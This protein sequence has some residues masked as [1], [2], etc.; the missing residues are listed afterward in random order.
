MRSVNS[1]N[2]HRLFVFLFIALSTLLTSAC[3]KSEINISLDKTNL[4]S[5]QS[6]Q[7]EIQITPPDWV[8]LWADN[9][10]LGYS[11]T[12]TA[13]DELGAVEETSGFQF[14]RL[15]ADASSCD[16]LD[17][18]QEIVSPKR[19]TEYQIDVN[20]YY[21]YCLFC[22]E[23]LDTIQK[24]IGLLL[25]DNTW[26]ETTRRETLSISVNLDVNI[27]DLEFADKNLRNCIN[28]T[29]LTR[30]LEV[31]N[32]DCGGYS[33]ESFEELVMFPNINELNVSGS[34]AVDMK[35]LVYLSDLQ[36]L[37][38]A[39]TNIQCEQLQELQLLNGSLDSIL[40]VDLSCEIYPLEELLTI[41]ELCVV[42]SPSYLWTELVVDPQ[43]N[44]TVYAHHV[45]TLWE[46]CE[47]NN[48]N[49]AAKFINI[50][51]L[52]QMGR[53][54]G[55]LSPLRD[56]TGLISIHLS[57]NNISDFSLLNQLP[58]LQS[59]TISGNPATHLELSGLQELD[60]IR[61]VSGALEWVSLS[62]LPN[63]ERVELTGNQ[64]SSLLIE[65]THHIR[66]LFLSG[67]A[68]TTTDFL[69][70]TSS[71][72][73]VLLDDNEISSIQPLNALTQLRF[74]SLENN[75]ISSLESMGVPIALE[76]IRLDGNRLTDLDDLSQLT[77]LQDISAQGNEI[78][79]LSDFSALTELGVLNLA[80]NKIQDL[81]LL[82]TA[83]GVFHL[84]LEDN[85]LEEV[86]DLIALTDIRRLHLSNNNLSDVTVISNL[87][88]VEV[89]TLASNGIE[90][91][92]GTLSTMPNLR[93]LDI[94]NNPTIPC[95]DLNLLINADIGFFTYSDECSE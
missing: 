67:N 44:R 84:A 4:D 1:L 36:T 29:G 9:T 38:V 54:V 88:S 45:H 90:F 56:L 5:T 86:N 60:R 58:R 92:A 35:P 39:D 48:F 30:S 79:R 72:E 50:Q 76:E 19:N 66:Q 69:G 53:G 42:R 28:N 15:T 65:D 46:P 93:N 89:L 8:K 27:A 94:S 6:A 14:C 77:L 26:F 59:I 33:L 37:D 2:H 31:S 74:L 82:S 41:P 23:E 87:E 49:D 20:Q 18:S 71:V 80:R 51:R 34:S 75:L 73:F 57:D 55:D 12:L 22:G 32:L 11:Y 62:D 91:G 16:E 78:E 61:A 43:P 81:S 21:V 52:S 17:V 24:F 3:S 83:S 95:N 68:F 25:S 63:L 13:V 7:F 10:S 40:G 85:L 47:I 70:A 64:I